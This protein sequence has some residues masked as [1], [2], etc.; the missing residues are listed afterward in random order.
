M[1]AWPSIPLLLVLLAACAGPRYQT[2]HVYQPPAD[3]AGRACAALCA[4]NLA[5]CRDDCT[6]GYR[7]CV[8]TLEP[9]ARKRHAD[10]LKRFQGE[11]AQYQRDLDTYH[12]NLSLG[13]G[14]YGDGWFGSGWH[15]PWWPYGYGS[16]YYPPAPPLAPRYEETL[17]RLLTEQC[18]QDCG[19]QPQHDACVLDC[20]GTRVLQRRCIAGCPP[21]P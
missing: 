17:E 12:L 11:L 21:A 16:R 10:A 6:N 18:R 13:W 20:G 19:C 7:D 15:D 9:E 2:L 5:G 1:R 14:Y 3:P 8:R 4:K